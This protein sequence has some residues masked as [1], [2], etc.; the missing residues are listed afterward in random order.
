MSTDPPKRADTA[1]R[2]EAAYRRDFARFLSVAT[3]ITGDLE[4]GADAVQEAFARALIKASKLR[5]PAALDGWLWRIIVNTARDHRRTVRRRTALV[6][7]LAHERPETEGHS[8]EANWAPPEL[9]RL[10]E[11][12]RSVIFLYY[13]ADLDHATIA[14]TLGVRRGTVSATLVQAR[15][16]IRANMEARDGR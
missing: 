11:R 8:L 12:Q 4:E 14:R 7:A 5:R 16:A 9:A 6:E 13:Y 3:A 10:T 1:T 15:D 2:I